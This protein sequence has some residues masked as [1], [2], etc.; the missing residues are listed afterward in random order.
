M[1]NCWAAPAGSFVTLMVHLPGSGSVIVTPVLFNA[2]KPNSPGAGRAVVVPGPLKFAVRKLRTEPFCS[3]PI[4]TV[5]KR[6]SAGTVKVFEYV[7][8]GPTV[9]LVRAI[10]SREKL[11]EGSPKLS[12]N[13]PSGVPSPA[14]RTAP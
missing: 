14:F 6:V 9:P 2:G 12:R 4:S 1:T 8:P 13:R 10:G 3:Q 11:T 7:E 5:A